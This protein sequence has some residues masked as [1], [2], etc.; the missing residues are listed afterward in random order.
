MDFTGLFIFLCKLYLSIIVSFCS[1]GNTYSTD[2]LNTLIVYL[3][4][5]CSY[6]CIKEYQQTHL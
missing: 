3:T 5:F 4:S 2:R 1:R 6:P